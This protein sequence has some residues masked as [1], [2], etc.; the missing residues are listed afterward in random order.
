QFLNFSISQFLNFSISQFLNFSISQFLNFSISQGEK[1][2]V[3]GLGIWKWLGN[4][5]FL[6]RS[7]E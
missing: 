1:Y 7:D 5:Y 3:L 6:R 2:G 4:E